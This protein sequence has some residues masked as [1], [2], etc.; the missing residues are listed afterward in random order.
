MKH[1]S[2]NDCCIKDQKKVFFFE[3][4]VKIAP[5]AQFFLVFQKKDFFFWSL[6]NQSFKN[7]DYYFKTNF[8][9]KLLG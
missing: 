7:H 6:I 5:L 8:K 3:K 9:F 2:P 1:I 4:Q